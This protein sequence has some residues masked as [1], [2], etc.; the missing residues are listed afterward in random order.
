MLLKE[1]Q[2]SLQS[3]F[4]AIFLDPVTISPNLS[5]KDVEEWDSL[6]QISIIVAVE[7]KFDIKF[8]TGEV[9]RTNNLGEFME[10]ISKRLVEH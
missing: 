9:E 1:I 6:L 8:R 4:D 2:N 7:K 3:I 5:A 10:I